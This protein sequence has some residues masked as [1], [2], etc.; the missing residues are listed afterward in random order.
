MAVRTELRDDILRR[1]QVKGSQEEADAGQAIEVAT[2]IDQLRAEHVTLGLV[3]YPQ[4]GIPDQI[5]LVLRDLVAW[6]MKHLAPEVDRAELQVDEVA[7][8]RNLRVQL[9]IPSSRE[10]TKAEYF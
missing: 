6:R 10:P 4:D 8:L 2:A 3:N 1:L 9:R 7:A 5:M